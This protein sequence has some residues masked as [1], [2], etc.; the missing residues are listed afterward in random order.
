MPYGTT[1][2]T[3]PASLREEAEGVDVEQPLVPTQHPQDQRLPRRSCRLA[4]PMSTA[5]SLMV[6]DIRPSWGR[7]CSEMS[8]SVM[9]L[10]RLIT[11]SRSDAGAAITSRSIPSTRKRIRRPASVGSTWTSDARSLTA[12]RRSLLTNPMTGC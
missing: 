4:A 1:S 12:R 3:D 7:R 11:P 8:M 2:G 5:T 6:I 9:I 10:M